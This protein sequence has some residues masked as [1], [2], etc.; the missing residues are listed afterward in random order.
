MSLMVEM[1]ILAA[2]SMVIKDCKAVIIVPLE[3]PDWYVV[4]SQ[5][6]NSMGLREMT[7]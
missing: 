6:E 2:C 3:A 5:L 1:N 7:E 4:P